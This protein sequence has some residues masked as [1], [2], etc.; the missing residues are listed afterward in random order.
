MSDTRAML[1]CLANARTVRLFAA[2]VLSESGTLPG[3]SA[4]EHR[5]LESLIDSGLIAQGSDSRL[6]VNAEGIR[7][8]L[9]RSSPERP[10]GTSRWFRA[11]GKIASYP[12]RPAE[13]RALLET[14]GATV[15]TPGERVSEG[16]LNA[17][18]TPYTDD[19]P[20]LRRYLVVH[21]ALN[22]ARDGSAYWRGEE[23]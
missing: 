19:I 14:V 5:D 16:E 3:L 22:R 15:L 10:S 20:T 13:R 8:I 21:G 17:R 9:R 23:Q 11:D 18:L 4:R 12:R 1:A 6:Q 7:A 2:I